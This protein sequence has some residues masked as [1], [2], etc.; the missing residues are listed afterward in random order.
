[1][2][3]SLLAA[4]TAQKAPPTHVTVAYTFVLLSM[5]GVNH[6][7]AGGQ[8]CVVMTFSVMFQ[9]L[10]VVLLG[11]QSL[12]TNS[13]SGIS[14]QALVLEALSLGFR[15]SSTVWLNGYL[16]VDKTGDFLFQA[17]DVCSLVIVIWLLHR[18]LVVQSGTYQASEDSMPIAPIVLVS[19]VLAMF[20]HGD[21]NGKPL[22]DALWMASLF[23]GVAQVLPQLWLIARQGSVHALTSHY[24]AALAISRLCSGFFMWISRKHI[25]CKPWV[26][27]MNH[28]IWIILAAHVIHLLLLA[29]FGYY[30][31]KAVVKQGFSARLPLSVGACTYV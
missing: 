1:M 22:F 3:A 2:P 4:S 18:V 7:F 6:C 10:A 24:I 5:F 13:A 23:M 14:A 21:M 30:Y 20:L 28:A 9:C 16:P 25:T 26:D 12:S 29:D 8:F 17:V 15:L 11:L 27:G 31:G 19:M